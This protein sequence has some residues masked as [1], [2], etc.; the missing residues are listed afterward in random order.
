MKKYLIYILLLLFTAPYIS[1]CSD[2]WTDSDKLSLLTK[3][4]EEE[5]IV[6]DDIDISLLK[7]GFNLNPKAETNELPNADEA[8]DIY[9][10]AEG[11]ELAEGEKECPLLGYQEACYLHAGV[12]SEGTWMYVPAA[13][14]EDT[15]KCKMV[16]VKENVWKITLSPTIRDWFGSGSTPIEQLGLIIRTT[17]GKKGIE[18]DTFVD[19]EDDKYN[20]FTPGEIKLE[21][22]PSGLQHGINI[23]DNHTVTLVL[24]EKDKDGNRYYD[25]AYVMGDFNNWKR[26]NDENSQ[27]YY[28]E[29][30]GCWWIT[31]S[32]LEPT[33]EY[34]FQYYLGKKS[35]VEGEKDTELRIADPYTE[36]ILDASS[37]S[38][39]PES[40][41]PSSQRIY[42]TK[43]AGVVSTFKIQKD[44]YSWA[45]DNF[46]IADKN[47][48]MIYELLLRDFTE[49]GDLQGAMQKLDYLE[50]LGITAIELMPVQ[51]FE[52]NDSWGYN[53][54][55]YF[56][57]DKAYGTS[58]MYKRFIDE[59]HKRGIAVLFDVVYN[60]ATGS[61][62]FARLYWDSKN[63]RTAENNPWFN[64]EARHAFNVFHDFNHESPLVRDFVKRNLKYLINEYHIDGF[65]FDLTKGFTQNGNKDTDVSG[66]D[67]SRISILRDYYNTIQS[68]SPNA[69]MICEHWADWAEENVLALAG[70][71]CWRKGSNTHDEG[72]YQSGM[73]Y[74]DRSSFSNLIQSGGNSIH[75]GGWVG[76]ME[77]HDEERIAYKAQVYGNE[78][79]KTDLTTR[80]NQLAANA[81]FCF[82]VP[83]PKMIWQFGE[84]GYDETLGEED[85]KTAKKP[86]H[87]EY[88]DEPAR[89]SLYDVYA[90]L[91]DLRK[92]H[93]NLFGQN[94][95]FSWK[96]ETADWTGNT[97]RT[98]SLKYNDKELVVVGN[99]GDDTTNY[100]LDSNIKYNYMTGDE[101]SGNITVEPHNFFL[102][103]SFRPE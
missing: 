59:C 15:E 75:F 95:T 25:Y 24:Y 92:T 71:Q 53:P 103:T 69:V 17:D 50:R 5:P 96:V 72:Y 8:L 56:A 97:P 36:K 101:V 68:I 70:I 49:T 83:G 37:D 23:I 19:I 13:W 63:N 18:E 30:A 74:S 85:E 11:K 39:I 84:L 58:E 14:T 78:K 22:M 43:G 55:F 94:A 27:M 99:F 52:G 32:G 40:T 26:S 102:G 10:Y 4:E 66:Y 73:G 93:A 87:W 6:E 31:L 88:Y 76:F 61:N 80:M 38:Y 33:K 54:T 21:S 89:K 47:N 60:H 9:F 65:R 86:L 20:S 98:I 16:R 51:E 46:K 67:E 3:A 57:L 2:E 35:T 12:Y 29:S 62:T 90:K 100:S 64:V 44:S 41:Y 28:D 81:A 48:L 91:L 42:P 1:S 77:S 7:F 79:I 34:A 45:H 82:T